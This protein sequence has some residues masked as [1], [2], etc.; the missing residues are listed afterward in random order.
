MHNYFCAS[1]KKNP[2]HISY[3]IYWPC[4]LLLGSLMQRNT[5]KWQGIRF[6]KYNRSCRRTFIQRLTLIK[7]LGPTSS[8]K[9]KKTID[10]ANK[11]NKNAFFYLSGL[12]FTTGVQFLFF[13]TI[14][15]YSKIKDL[16]KNKK[17]S[18]LTSIN[19]S[20]LAVNRLCECVI[21]S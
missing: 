18:R 20:T 13:L 10:Y 15:G 17:C 19:M 21:F 6:C 14:R 9:I 4:I 3:F 16:N 2:V 7:F 1:R 12:T 5:Y 8:I 11:S